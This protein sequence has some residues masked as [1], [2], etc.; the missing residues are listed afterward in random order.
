MM[1]FHIK[2]CILF[3]ISYYHKYLYNY[4]EVLSEIFGVIQPK[5]DEGEIPKHM[6]ELPQAITTVLFL[7]HLRF[8]IAL[9]SLNLLQVHIPF[10]L[11]CLRRKSKKIKILVV[12][13]IIK[14]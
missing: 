4:S 3:H 11:F 7:I 8:M 14:H 2:G 10:F 6:T 5:A 12:V 9:F 13:F 1:L